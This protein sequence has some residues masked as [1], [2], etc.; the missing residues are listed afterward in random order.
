[1]M[2]ARS[3][4]PVRV[5][6]YSCLSKVLIIFGLWVGGHAQAQTSPVAELL[7]PAS[8]D[9][10]AQ[11]NPS[12]AAIDWA[13]RLVKI[14]AAFEVLQ[15][16]PAAP[17]FEERE[18]LTLRLMAQ[19]RQYLEQQR[20][21]QSSLPTGLDT[22][23]PVTLER[24]PP[25][26]VLEVDQLR[27]RRDQLLARKAA[28]DS[29]LKHIEQELTG[30]L[31]SLRKAEE[32]L[33]LQAEIY[34]RALAS[35]SPQA[36]G[37]LGALET[38]KLQLELA[39]LDVAR[40]DEARPPQQAQMQAVEAQLG[41]LNAAL[42]AARLQQKLDERDLQA[43]E[44]DN[45]KRL[46]ALEAEQQKAALQLAKWSRATDNPWTQREA[47]SREG[48]IY[49]LGQ[50]VALVRGDTEIWSYR[51]GALQAGHDARSQREARNA[52][53]G[54]L[55]RIDG[56]Q[57]AAQEQLRFLQLQLRE[58]QTDTSASGSSGGSR[59][60]VSSRL[61]ADRGR[62]LQALIR[63]TDVQQR[64]ISHL[65]RT[66]L[67]LQ[68]SLED[69][70]RQ[71]AATDHRRTSEDFKTWLSGWAQR[72]WQFELFSAT[73]TTHVNGRSVTV[74]YGVTVGKSVGALV[75]F[76]LGYL[77]ARWLTQ[78]FV[79]Q[80]SLRMGLSPQLARVIQR[81]LL[82]F[83]VVLVLLI[84]LRMARVPLTAFAFLGGALAIGIGFGAQNVI[85][86]LISGVIIL[87]ERKVRVGDTVT[88]GSVSGEV[89]AVDLRATTIRGFDGIEAI[90]P[91]STLLEQQVSN[92]TS[93]Q[94]VLRRSIRLRLA[95]HADIALA[96][97]L[98]LTCA[99]KHS[100]VLPTPAPDVLLED[101]QADAA[102][103]GLY[104][105]LRL[106]G[107]RS[108]PQVD[109]DLRGALDRLLQDY[110]LALARPRTVIQMF[111]PPAHAKSVTD[112]ARG[113]GSANA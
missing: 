67:L 19:L 83:L 34:E 56:R 92:W 8:A 52:I 38:A 50:L 65:D 35:Q 82:S 10:S 25:Y 81:W 84:V 111:K 96:R 40:T 13:D 105:W 43:L 11:A 108:G 27:D 28:L 18:R 112:I 89:I 75:L 69:F 77:I 21:R 48:E 59:N 64:V 33:R 4:A 12:A 94:P 54:A 36:V 24:Q 14:Q 79:R 66:R 101:L 113:I 51:G 93:G 46:D 73:E 45:L 74:D 20:L 49:A 91:N 88:V 55:V 22:S 32:N 109:S 78:A 17:A 53:T 16:Q 87:F 90:I 72:L 80:L 44:R 107:P 5:R 2:A 85:K 1:M 30:A 104:Y 63:H 97:K 86:N 71:P 15:T 95:R 9:L 26:S 57:A 110:H 42:D 31:Q 76:V 47:A 62:A 23:A 6:A 58:L 99:Q 106:D 60:G 70:S 29:G 7:R 100:S 103:L 102:E 98:M 68:R 37:A 61:E 41:P 3:H 39:Q